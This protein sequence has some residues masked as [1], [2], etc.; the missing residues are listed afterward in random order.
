MSVEKMSVDAIHKSEK[1]IFVDDIS[2]DKMVVAK[3]L[4]NKMSVD[5]IPN[6][7]MS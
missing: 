6:A 7:K 4:V 1:K 5:D 2:I 3:T